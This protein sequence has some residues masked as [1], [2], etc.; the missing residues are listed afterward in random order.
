MSGLFAT[1]WLLLALAALPAL[2]WLLRARPPAPRR[3]VFPPTALLAGLA[4][5]ETTPARTPWWLL[6]LRGLAVLALVLGFAGPR[7]APPQ[8]GP[9][10]GALLLVIDNGWA[11]A[12]DWPARRDAALAELAQAAAAHRPVAWLATAGNGAGTMRVAPALPAALARPVLAALQPMPW[13]VDRDRA[14]AALRAW[15]R[16]GGSAGQVVYLADGLAGRGNARAFA[17]LLA[18]IAPVTE[19][20]CGAPPLLLAAP[21]AAGVA[22]KGGA[23]GK[24]GLAVTLRS[25]PAPV[26]RPIAVLAETGDGRVLARSVV[27]LA[28]GAGQA[29]GR[30]ALPGRLANRVARLALAGPGAAGAG[31]TVLLDERWRRPAVGLAAGSAQPAPPLAD[32]GFYLRMALAPYAALAE[33]PVATLLAQPLSL[34][35]LPDQPLPPGKEATQIAAWVRAGGVLLRFAGPHLAAE[36]LGGS[37]PLAGTADAGAPIGA[38]AGR[39]ALLPVTLLGGSR[40]LGGAMSWRAPQALAPFPANSPFAGL[41]VPADV[42]VRRQVLADPAAPP[43]IPSAAGKPAQI[44]ARLADGTP[45]VTAARLGAGRIVLFHVTAN[46]DWS[47]L[48]LSGLFVAML[49]RLTALAAGVEVPAGTVP[50]APL[51]TLDGFGTAGPPPAAAT[52]LAAADFATT[53]A[54]FRHPPGVY[55]H[56][57][58]RRTLNLG[59]A[60]GA[61][62]AMAAIPGARRL[63]LDAQAV[64]RGFGPALIG[65]AVALLIGDLALSL[66]LRGLLG[67]VRRRMP[68]A[69]LLLAASL[70]GAARAQGVAADQTPPAGL[71]VVANPALAT[72]LAYVQTGDAAQDAISRAGLIGLSEEVDR[73]TAVTLVM[74]DA[75]VPGRSDLSFYPL[76]YWPILPGAAPPDAAAAAA[77]DAFMAHG[78]MLLI[79]AGAGASEGAGAGDGAGDGAGQGVDLRQA[80]AGLAIP[81][82]MRLSTAHVLTRTFYLL[83]EFP[84][85][86]VGEPVWVARAAPAGR[87]RTSPVVI[88]ANDWAAAW[89]V[90]AAGDHPYAAIPGGERQRVYAIRFGIN[91]VMY[92][93]TGTYKEDQARVPALL[94]R[95][96]R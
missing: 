65:L 85:R 93:L 1:P 40:R 9:G 78:G 73:R 63:G 89:A 48:P 5:R 95:L 28:A 15:R 83:H 21:P 32:A 82:L 54:S 29:A 74:P 18:A 19:R 50:L 11:D 25:L 14:A 4:P 37:L 51:R 47:N 10:G 59:D 3:Q 56:G 91:L 81:A 45:L 66:G 79:D 22:G 41:A 75:V 2:W 34:L 80:L 96:G 90:D 67:P 84:G 36:D 30:I 26:T 60:A 17:T 57:A 52:P 8:P 12:P 68:V 69:M 33:A 58:A 62:A 72:R 42:T 92:A 53:P 55:G 6:A 61:L 39:D 77:L 46:A 86:Y 38:A 49:H 20:C 16:G 43:P 71:P 88:G 64:P 70:A 31:G 13:S 24:E 87:D 7:L 44:W 76:L 94:E 35:I 27:T 23:A